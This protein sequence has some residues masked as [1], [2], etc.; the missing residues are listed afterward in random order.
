[1]RK[2][3]T[4][5]IEGRDEPV[6]VYEL[7]IKQIIK[8]IQGDLL[9]DL[10]LDS[11]KAQLSDNV[12]PKC[13]NL[14]LDEMMEMAPSELNLIWEKFKEVNSTFF[15]LARKAGLQEVLESTIN[16]LKEA[17]LGDFSKLL[18]DSSKQD[19]STS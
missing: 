9:A 12:L 15:D 7:T 10:S 14:K 5:S 11:F 18:V 16:N 13:T 6:V 8:L 1:M 2:T 3:E 19:I 4:L 17:M